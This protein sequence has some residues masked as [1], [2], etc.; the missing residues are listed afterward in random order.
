MRSRYKKI[1]QD[2]T[3]P[4]APKAPA[5]ASAEDEFVAEL[6]RSYL[7]KWADCQ[8]MA[9]ILRVETLV[10]Q[11]PPRCA[12]LAKQR[13]WLSADGTKVLAAGFKVAAAYLRR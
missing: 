12:E 4:S 7:I 1:D 8:I 9:G 10:G 2:P 3:Q 5:F 11:A 13:K 6:T